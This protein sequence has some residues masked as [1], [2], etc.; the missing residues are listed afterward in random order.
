M[1]GETAKANGKFVAEPAGVGLT[2]KEDDAVHDVV[3]EA[4]GDIVAAVG[5]DVQPDLVEVGLGEFRETK[6]LQRTARRFEAFNA[7]RRFRPLAFT[8]VASFDRDAR[9][10][11]V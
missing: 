4:I 5:G 11:A 6:A 9:S 2:G 7:A 1:D 10:C 8:R 3:N